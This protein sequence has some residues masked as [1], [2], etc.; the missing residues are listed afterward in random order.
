M[1][2]EDL[3]SLISDLVGVEPKSVA[4]DTDA[5]NAATWISMQNGAEL[6]AE[7][8]L[9]PAIK[10][11][12]AKHKKLTAERKTIFEKLE[13][14]KSRVRG[15]L[16]NFIGAGHKVNGCYTKT[17]YKITVENEALLPAEYV[18]SV[19]DMD[20][21]EAWVKLTEGKQAIPGI[22]VEKVHV[23]VFGEK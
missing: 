15:A 21:I 3:K 10:E 8:I 22:S 7:T 12:Y 4:T 11:A 13:A 1:D 16:A 18:K 14:A 6:E 17:S 20:G 23:L 5:H 19:P 2:I 9:G